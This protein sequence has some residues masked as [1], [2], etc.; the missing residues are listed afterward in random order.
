MRDRRPRHRGRAS[1]RS[2]RRRAPAR[3]SRS[4]APARPAWPAR[5]SSRAPVTR[6]TSTSAGPRPAGLLRYGIP[7][8]K[9]EKIHVDR[10]V[11]QMEAEGVEFHYGAHVGVNV[12]ADNLLKDY[13]AVVLTGGAEE[14]AR[15]A[16][17]RPRAQ[18]HPFRHGFSAAAEPP[19]LRREQ[20]TTAS[21]SSPPASMSSSSAAAIPA[22][23]ASA[24][25]SA[26]ARC[27]SPISKSC[28]S[29]R[30]TRTRR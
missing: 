13:D 20:P 8:F 9:M 10:R 22:R 17:A 4:S 15:P 11:A 16:G 3:K 29:R 28:R 25:R 1:S 23:T 26:R 7:D 5:S 6:S 19:R 21:R 12:P 14:A 24:P 2:R 27:R 30:C 18:G